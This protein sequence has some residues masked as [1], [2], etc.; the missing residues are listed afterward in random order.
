M[1]VAGIKSDSTDKGKKADAKGK[2]KDDKSSNKGDKK[3]QQPR[4]P[5]PK[6]QTPEEKKAFAQQLASLS[7][8]GALSCPFTVRA[9]SNY[10]M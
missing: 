5:P 10:S 4:L 6:K 2:K 1:K 8:V 9:G 3:P 7:K